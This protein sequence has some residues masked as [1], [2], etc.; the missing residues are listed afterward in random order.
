MSGLKVV[1]EKEVPM[2]GAAQTPTAEDHQ[3]AVRW[4]VLALQTVSLRFATAMGLAWHAT[5][6]AALAGSAWWL[7][8]AVL[9]APDPGKLIGATIYSLFCLAVMWLR[10]A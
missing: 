10:R 5:F 8:A 6:T 9:I 3:K 2:P 1:S 7:W 4:L